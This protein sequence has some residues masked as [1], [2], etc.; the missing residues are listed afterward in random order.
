MNISIYYFFKS[1]FT[2]FLK[3]VMRLVRDN[4]TNVHILINNQCIVLKLKTLCNISHFK[5]FSEG[6]N[7]L[8][9]YVEHKESQGIGTRCG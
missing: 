6:V 3:I 1:V 7:K 4:A 9:L 2:Y 8:L 5:I